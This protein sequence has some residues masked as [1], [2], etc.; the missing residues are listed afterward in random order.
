MKAQ[1]LLSRLTLGLCGILLVASCS[2]SN[3]NQEATTAEAQGSQVFPFELPSQKPNI[4]MSSSTKRM[5]DDYETPRVQ[6]CELFTQFK[7]T[8]LKG[9][10]Y[11]NGD[12]TVSRRDPSRP[13][14]V[15]GKYHIWYTHR[16]TQVPPIGY[17]RAKEATDIIPSTDWDLCDIWHAT[18]EDGITWEEQGPAITRPEKPKSGRI[19]SYNVCYTKLL[20]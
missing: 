5:F 12:G 18:S 9:F 11:N 19:T 15:D 10:D 6:D 8:R 13:I 4:P 2:N 3:I 7:Y 17:A 20:R 1:T 16:H 14:L